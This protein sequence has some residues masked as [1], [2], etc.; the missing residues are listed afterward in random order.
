MNDLL[1]LHELTYIRLKLSQQF[2]VYRA[3]IS[4]INSPKP[5]QKPIVGVDVKKSRNSLRAS[6]FISLVEQEMRDSEEKHCRVP[7]KSAQSDD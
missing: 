5:N 4:V 6:D 7:V 3:I 1:T 2:A